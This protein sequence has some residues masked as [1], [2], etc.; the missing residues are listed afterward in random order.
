MSQYK[1]EIT[2]VYVN[3]EGVAVI[4]CPA[5][6]LVKTTKV[7]NFKGSKHVLKVRCT[8]K[9]VFQVHLEFRKAWRKE[10]KLPGDYVLLPEKIHRGRMMV[11]NISKTGIGLQVVGA[12]RLQAGE[13][14]Q[15]S[16]I[17]DDTHGSKIDKKVV[18][19]MVKGT[20]IGCEFLEASPHDRA[21]GFY[22]MA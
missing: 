21:L 8:C 12:N 20:Y 22:M 1:E 11:S 17:L 14:L 16:F 3:Q 15:V 19:R 18:I 4:K 13:K 9:N 2:K 5:C 7:V 10:I 6:E